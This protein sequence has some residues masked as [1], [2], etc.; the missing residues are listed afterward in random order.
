MKQT[1]KMCW[2]DW[3]DRS[4]ADYRLDDYYG[5]ITLHNAMLEFEREL[6]PGSTLNLTEHVVICS[7]NWMAYMY[8]LVESVDFEPAENYKCFSHVYKPH[9]Q[10]YLNEILI[11]M[12]KKHKKHMNPSIYKEIYSLSKDS[13]KNDI[14]RY[15][16]KEKLV[17]V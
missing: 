14:V 12:L 5:D 11:H 3:H 9:C 15:L 8:M 16:L 1:T 7:Q 6:T 2:S 4:R 13:G 17:D 10:K